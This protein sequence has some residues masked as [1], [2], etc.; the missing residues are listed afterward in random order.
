V[1]GDDDEAL[2]FTTVNGKPLL[3]RYFAP[4]WQRAKADAGVDPTVQFRDLR[5]LAGPTAA[6]A[7]A[8]LREIMSRMG[9][10]S[11]DAALRY[12]KASERR[13]AE[14]ANAIDDRLSGEMRHAKTSSI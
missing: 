2:V 6:S 5:H 4:F 14:I 13:D 11:S 10:A 7:G 1:D 9:H 3:N 8:S 12:L